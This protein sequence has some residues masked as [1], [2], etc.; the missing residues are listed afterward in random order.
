VRQGSQRY[1]R[2]RAGAGRCPPPRPSPANSAGEGDASRTSGALRGRLYAEWWAAP[3]PA[4]PQKL[5]VG[6]RTAEKLVGA[7]SNSPLSPR[8]EGGGAGG[9]AG[10]G[11]L[12]GRSSMSIAEP[13]GRNEKSPASTPGPSVPPYL[14]TSVP[15]YLRTSVPPYLRTFVPSYRLTAPAPPGSPE[16][17]RRARRGRRCTRGRAW[18]RRASRRRAL[19]CRRP[20]WRR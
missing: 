6:G 15:P 10:G 1:D 3:S 14:R 5:R 8:N 11:G 19:P 20:A 4:L 16:S 2:D 7:G 18:L 13:P 9:G 17:P 12:G